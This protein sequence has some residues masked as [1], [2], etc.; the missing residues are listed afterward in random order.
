MLKYFSF[1]LVFFLLVSCGSTDNI[2]PQRYLGEYYGTQEPYEMVVGEETVSIP[3]TEYKL[4]LYYNELF[5][6][7]PQ[8]IIKAKYIVKEETKS[9]Y[10]FLVTLEN[11]VIEEWKLLK[12]E[13][14]LIRTPSKPQ[15]EITFKAEY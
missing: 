4:S 10:L 11:G 7:S 2:F 14:Q 12:K 1:L 15:P 3:E 9:S 8:Q 13:E 6:K 5:L